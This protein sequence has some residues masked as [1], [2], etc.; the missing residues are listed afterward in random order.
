MDVAP[1]LTEAAPA[2]DGV[3]VCP[4]CG[5]EAVPG[6]AVSTALFPGRTVRRCLRCGARHEATPGVARSVVE[7][8]SCGLPFL[9]DAVAPT[10]DVTC[11]DCLA[12]RIPSDLSAPEVAEASEGE[13][14]VALEDAWSF[15]GSNRQALYLDRLATQIRRRLDPSPGRVRVLIFEDPGRRTLALPSGTVLLS[16][17]T[18]VD[19]ED[20]AELAFVLAHELAHAASS[21]AS[22]RLVR[23]GLHVVAQEH[24]EASGSPWLH[25]A[26]DLIRLG[27]G[28]EREREADREAV[29]AILDLGY[30]P[31]AVTR[32][33]Q[34]LD[35]RI[36]A[37]ESDVAEIA[38]AHPSPAARLRQLDEI[39]SAQTRP[40]TT[41]RVDREVFRRAVGREALTRLLP[42]EGPGRAVQENAAPTTSAAPARGRAW[43]IAAL[44][45]LAVAAFFV[46]RQLL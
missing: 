42:A 30:D 7:C 12:E 5:A 24:V 2:T 13:M 8:S 27:Y 32:Y 39:L 46:A 19:L 33:L 9:H 17:G 20:E 45:L 16:M 15:V 36:R 3:A 14:R 22:V 34:R 37:G 41:L 43:L 26:E 21:D 38:L 44:V 28:N 29:R 11:P 10:S 23:T 35:A 25:A 18:L 31:R 6:N 4:A 1:V 40:R